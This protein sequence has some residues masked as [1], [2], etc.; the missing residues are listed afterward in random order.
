VTRA[1]GD[2]LESASEELGSCLIL[3]LVGDGATLQNSGTEKKK[4]LP[5]KESFR[6]W[7]DLLLRMPTFP[8]A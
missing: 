6:K 1:G 2:Q 7:S 3:Q 8:P 4:Y 5:Y